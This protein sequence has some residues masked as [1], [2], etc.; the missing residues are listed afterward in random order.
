LPAFPSKADLRADL[1]SAN[2]EIDGQSDLQVF[3]VRAG[4]AIEGQR[5][6]DVPTD[7]SILGVRV[8]GAIN[9]IIA[10]RRPS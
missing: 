5:L 10:R 7:T 4:Q 6:V 3:V 9:A 8:V 2:D 1:Q